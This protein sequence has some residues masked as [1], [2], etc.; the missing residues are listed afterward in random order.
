MQNGPSSSE[1]LN[2][3][4]NLLKDRIAPQLEG[5]DAYALRVAINSLGIVERE[6]L[7][8]QDYEQKEKARLAEILGHDGDAT[9]LNSE[10]CEKIRS[11][12]FTQKDKAVLQHLKLTAIDQVQLDQPKY[13][14]L[15]DALKR[16]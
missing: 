7:F 2:A 11:G 6:I 16:I 10:L 9:E 3:I 4:R 1:I 15:T 5:H 8:R 13:S 14:G 12:H